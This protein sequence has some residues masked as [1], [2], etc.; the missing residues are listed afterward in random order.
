MNYCNFKAE[1][2]QLV[3]VVSLFQHTALGRITYVSTTGNTI[4]VQNGDASWWVPLDQDVHLIRSEF[5][6]DLRELTG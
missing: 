4:Q 2:G 5:W 3:Y 1:V 6:E